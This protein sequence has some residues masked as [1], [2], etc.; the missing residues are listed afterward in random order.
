MW[1]LKIY[2]LTHKRNNSS[3]YRKVL[4]VIEIDSFNILNIYRFPSYDSTLRSSKVLGLGSEE[5][6]IV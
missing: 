2:L 4:D 3:I 1:I 5:K 6:R